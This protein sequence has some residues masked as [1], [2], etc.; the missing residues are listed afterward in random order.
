MIGK[1]IIYIFSLLTVSILLAFGCSSSQISNDEWDGPTKTVRIYG[2][3]SLDGQIISASKN[4][5]LKDASDTTTGS[6]GTGDGIDSIYDFIDL[7]CQFIFDDPSLS[8]TSTGIDVVDDESKCTTLN[9]CIVCSSDLDDTC[10]LSCTGNVPS[11]AATALDYIEIAFYVRAQ[12]QTDMPQAWSDEALIG[13]PSDD[14]GG[15]ILFRGDTSGWDDFDP[16]GSDS[17]ASID[18]AFNRVYCDGSDGYMD[19][20]Y[21]DLFSTDFINTT[22]YER[23]Y[24]IGDLGTRP[25]FPDCVIDHYVFGRIYLTGADT[26]GSTLDLTDGMIVA[27]A[28][29]CDDLHNCTTTFPSISD[30]MAKT[31]GGTGDDQL[32]IEGFR[33]TAL[34]AGEDL[35][36]AG[37]TNSFGQGGEDGSI[38][39]LASD[40]SIVSEKVY[41]F[42]GSNHNERFGPIYITDDGG[43]VTAGFASTENYYRQGYVRKFGTGAFEKAYGSTD[44]N[45][46]EEFYD[47]IQTADGGYAVAGA[48]S[49]F[50]ADSDFDFWIVK[51]DSS[52]NV[53][54]NGLFP[55]DGGDE[56]A[57]SIHETSTGDLLVA[58]WTMA[59]N[60]GN[61]YKDCRVMKLSPSGADYA[62]SFDKLYKAVGKTTGDDVCNSIIETSDNYYLVAGQTNNNGAPNA[63]L[64]KLNSDGTIVWQKDYAYTEAENFH[65]A[66]ELSDG[67][68]LAVGYTGTS[69]YSVLKGW[70]VKINPLDGSILWE[71][72]YDL[73]TLDFLSTFE[74]LSDGSL[75][76]VGM[77]MFSSQWDILHITTDSSG[78]MSDQCTIDSDTAATVS[79]TNVDDNTSTGV[80]GSEPTVQEDVYALTE[81]D[82]SN[83]ITTVCAPIESISLDFARAY[84]GSSDEMHFGFVDIKAIPGG[85]YRVVGITDS[86]GTAPTNG[87]VMEFNEIGSLVSEVA[88]GTAASTLF[89]WTDTETSD[90]GNIVIG[91][92]SNSD[93]DAWLKKFGTGA[94][95]K[96]YSASCEPPI[97]DP[98]VSGDEY[99]YTVV[100]ATGGY[101]AV[102]TT[103]ANPSGTNDAFVMMINSAGDSVIWNKFLG[104]GDQD[105][106][107]SIIVDSNGDVVI[108]GKTKSES[109]GEEDA[110]IIKLDPD[111]P[112]DTLN[113]SDDGSLIWQTAYGVGNGIDES[114]INIIESADGHYLVAGHVDDVVEDLN[115][116]LLKIDANNGSIIWQKEYGASGVADHEQFYSILQVSDGGYVLTGPAIINSNGDGY[117]LAVKVN[118]AGTI[119][120]QKKY[121]MEG[122]DAII[123]AAETPDG[124]FMFVGNTNSIGAGN[125]DLLVISTDENGELGSCTIDTDASLS[126]SSPSLSA[127]TTSQTLNSLSITA[128]DMSATATDPAGVSSE[129][130]CDAESAF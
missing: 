93:M 58:G 19:A 54:W 47:I 70:G 113:T 125:M 91:N 65:R 114:L 38:L 111:G 77:R 116:L 96:Y 80:A 99:T 34:T 35:L 63:W 9:K 92:V 16:S 36:I 97:C 85:G 74:E 122:T 126:E 6:G 103:T 15:M 102:G 56:K 18:T 78:A 4:L 89:S 123:S 73:G 52:G 82:M 43:Y 117:G 21:N 42:S 127:T 79:N 68:Y 20:F 75:A 10:T 29:I 106:M 59:F 104:G 83:S 27:N 128:N 39:Q 53:T 55:G 121:N 32:F 25:D 88:Y 98:A 22:G 71:K 81:S 3:S 8:P 94:F 84:G 24:V 57:V 44:L 5:S 110:W 28:F 2:R 100:E 108:A 33:S 40:G 61:G 17:L 60:G 130:Q 105:E 76:F 13:D 48:S 109:A 72:A 14:I 66:K 87:L 101:V 30:Q 64:M 12:F 118:S 124:G 37:Y 23:T 49:G 7:K 119:L 95:E 69:D 90:G 31:Y 50:G 1:K 115:G 45:E 26:P 41:G 51:L 11:N 46:K 86:F 120:W 129:A 107:Y 112:D 67:N 62:I